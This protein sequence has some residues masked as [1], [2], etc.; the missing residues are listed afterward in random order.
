MN[1]DRV[2][3]TVLH[4]MAYAAQHRTVMHTLIGQSGGWGSAD[5]AQ[6]ALRGQLGKQKQAVEMRIANYIKAIGDGRMSDALLSA[7][8]KAEV[9]KAEVVQQIEVTDKEI[10][11]ATMQRPTAALV[12]EGWGRVGEVWK[13]LT[14][15]E[16]ADLLGSFVQTVEMTEKKSVTLELLPVVMSHSPSYS[17]RFELNSHLGAGVGLEPTTFGL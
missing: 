4:F 1:A 15:A 2:H 6:K 12:Q 10:S 8:D 9:E 14:E 16:R 5:E 17:Q 3:A 11:A 13:V 7:L